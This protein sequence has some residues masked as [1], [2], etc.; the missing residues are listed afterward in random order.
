[1]R[2][3][4]VCYSDSSFVPFCECPRK[5]RGA[6]AA[7]QRVQRI[8][9]GHLGGT[10]CLSRAR[11]PP[12]LR[13]GATIL[14]APF[15][16]PDESDQRVDALTSRARSIRVD[17]DG[18]QVGT[19]SGRMDANVPGPGRQMSHGCISSS[20]MSA[21]PLPFRHVVASAHG[22]PGSCAARCQAPLPS[23]RS[24]RCPSRSMFA[25]NAGR[26]RDVQKLASKWIKARRLLESG[27]GGLPCLCI[28]DMLHCSDWRASPRGH[29]LGRRVPRSIQ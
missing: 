1:M 12:S 21:W 4:S 2:R 27:L 18:A 24:G 16:A 15:R 19:D 9:V 29:E 13:T 20:G 23:S 3:Q 11:D 25:R 26:T 14:P 8:H 6:L 7:A 17:A 22:V 10:D 5:R 28:S